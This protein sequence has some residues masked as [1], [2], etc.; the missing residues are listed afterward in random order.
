MDDDLA[1]QVPQTIG[2]LAEQSLALSDTRGL[3]E[4]QRLA[5][6]QKH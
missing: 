4:F 2:D 3:F 1:V 5:A 6:E